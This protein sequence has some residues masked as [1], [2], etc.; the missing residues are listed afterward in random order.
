MRL[1]LLFV[2]GTLLALT[3]SGNC[4]AHPDIKLSTAGTIENMGVKTFLFGVDV[5]N[6]DN[7]PLQ[8]SPGDFVASSPFGSYN[9]TG[10]TLKLDPG[11]SGSLS[12]KASGAVSPMELVYRPNG[13]S[14]SLAGRM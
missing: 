13:E 6:P 14:L 7:S 3:V 1:I 9:L 11:A 10:N 2:L 12:L 4:I 5:L 8:V